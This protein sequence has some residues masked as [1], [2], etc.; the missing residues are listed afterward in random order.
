MSL[1]SGIG[2]CYERS[3]DLAQRARIAC[4]GAIALHDHDGIAFADTRRMYFALCDHL[5]TFPPSQPVGLLL[6]RHP[7][8]VLAI[9]AALETG[10]PFV[11]LN[12]DWPSS[13]VESVIALTGCKVLDDST[14][15]VI[16]RREDSAP[17][18]PPSPKPERIA[19]IIC[20]SGTSGIPKAV[21]ISRD[22]FASF[23]RWVESYF[24]TI[25]ADDRILLSAEFTFD[26]SMLNLALLLAGR[27]QH[28]LSNVKGDAFALAAQIERDQITTLVTVPN[29]MSSLLMN[30]VLRRRKIGC[31]QHLLLGGSRFAYG[32]YEAIQRHLPKARCYNLYGPTECT[33]YCHAKT[34]SGDPAHDVL[35]YNISVGQPIRG[36]TCLVIDPAG[37]VVTAPRTPGELWIGGVQ[38]LDEYRGSPEAT[39]SAVVTR[40]GERYYRTGDL[41]FFD[42]RGDYYVTG[43]LDETLKRRGYRVNLL[44]ID[45]YVQRLAPVRECM[46]IAVPHPVYEH[47][48]VTYVVAHT[49]VAEDELLPLMREV[50][51]DYEL[52]DE[53]RFVTEL[54][55]GATGK[56]DRK[57][58]ERQYATSSVE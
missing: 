46:T 4:D 30:A 5:T 28:Y 40:D 51:V 9:C 6:D 7:R 15:D 36:A 52:P 47:K 16:S 11:P 3:V 20:T 54:P 25:T 31:I 22:A 33:V 19:Y 50:L 48:L 38:V 56:V 58:L 39:A 41:G 12:L 45:S 1:R 37:G 42:D 8:Y 44:N 18:D 21:V 29:T 13:R 2:G 23:V 57:Q 27:G 24:S 32:A 55:R 10:T 26:M 14:I 53:I 49:A 43:R 34:L 35:D 17:R